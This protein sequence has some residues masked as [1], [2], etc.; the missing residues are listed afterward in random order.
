MPLR[1]RTRRKPK[2][3]VT[4]SVLEDAAGAVAAMSVIVRQVQ[5]VPIDRPL[6][7]DLSVLNARRAMT[8]LLAPTVVA[9]TVRQTTEM[10]VATAQVVIVVGV[11]IARAAGVMIATATVD[12]SRRS[13]IF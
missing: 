5:K 4:A 1:P 8:A 6:V 11:R 12:H 9:M 2:S 10:S 7:I 3:A 13:L